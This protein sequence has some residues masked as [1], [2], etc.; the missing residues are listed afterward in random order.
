MKLASI[1]LKDIVRLCPLKGIKVAEVRTV[2][3]HLES[4]SL[5]DAEG[6]VMAFSLYEH[7]GKEL[8]VLL[9][10]PPEKLNRY[11][12]TGELAGGVKVNE[13]FENNIDSVTRKQE[14]LRTYPD[15][16]LEINV[17]EVEVEEP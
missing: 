16:S 10:A 8:H 14:L 9:K 13:T 2:N 1:D 7:Y 4:V 11:V 3:G 15:A 6:N 12:L 17:L 5:E